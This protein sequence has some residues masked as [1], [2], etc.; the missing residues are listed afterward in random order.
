MIESK[1]QLVD[2]HIQHDVKEVYADKKYPRITLHQPHSFGGEMIGFGII[3]SL[4][5]IYLLQTEIFMAAIILI[6]GLLSISGG[7]YRLS[8]P[9]YITLDE[10]G[11]EVGGL[12]TANKKTRW[13]DVVSFEVVPVQLPKGGKIYVVSIRYVDSY[14]KNLTLRNYSKMYTGAE[15]AVERYGGKS[16]QEMADLLN[17]YRDYYM[18]KGDGYEIQGQ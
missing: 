8:K 6:F 14:E 12:A 2:D 15:G 3:A 10:D 16:A 1:N 18:K 9:G 13:S 7:F 17:N 5:G 4:Y 11:F